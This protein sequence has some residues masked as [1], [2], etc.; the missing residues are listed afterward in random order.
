MKG[1][2]DS[3]ATRLLVVLRWAVLGLSMAQL[4]ANYDRGWDRDDARPQA[5]RLASESSALG[6]AMSEQTSWRERGDLEVPR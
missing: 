4:Q 3:R 1:P 6:R 5:T 2:T